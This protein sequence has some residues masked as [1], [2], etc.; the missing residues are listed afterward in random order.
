M[1]G[2]GEMSASKEC[3][4]R[5]C[6]ALMFV[7]LGIILHV[8]SLP[9]RSQSRSFRFLNWA[10]L[11]PTFWIVR[12][13]LRT[14]RQPPIST[15]ELR[16]ACLECQVPRLVE[17]LQYV[18]NTERLRDTGRRASLVG[19]ATPMYRVHHDRTVDCLQIQGVVD[20]RGVWSA[21]P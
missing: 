2:Q 17:N 15:L 3:D 9:P 8:G 19:G 13:Q 20:M 12:S 5:T 11:L 1:P 16:V 10:L 7:A 21:T 18:S 4:F 6:N 14:L